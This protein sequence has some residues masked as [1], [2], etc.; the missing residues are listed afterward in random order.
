MIGTEATATPTVTGSTSSGST[1]DSNHPYYLHSSDAPGM[2]LVSSPFDGRG[3]T[4]WRRSVL[5]AISAKNKLG[6]INGTCLEPAL[7]A[8]EHSQW[9]RCN[10][11]V[12]S[13]LL[14]SLTKEIG[15]SVIYSRT[16]KDLWGSL[17]HRFGQSSGAKLYHLQISKLAQGSSSIAGYFT[18]LKRLW[19][20]LDSINSH[21][22][23]TCDCTCDGKKKIAKFMEDQ[24]VIQ[25]LMGLN[26]VYAQARGNILMMSPLPGIDQ[27]YSL[28]LQDESQREIY[29]NPSYSTDVASFMV[30]TQNKTPQRNNQIQR[31]WNP[32]Q[33]QGNTQQKFK[34]KKTR[35][36]P[37][38]A[39]SHCM[40]IGHT[41]ADC[42]RLNGFPDDF[43]FTKSNISQGAVK[44]NALVQIGNGGNPGTEINA[45]AVAGTILKY[46]GT[47]LAVPLMRRGQAFG[48]VRD[49]LYLLQPSS[50][51][52]RILFKQNVISTPKGSN[53]SLFSP[54][55]PF[56]APVFANA[57]SNVRE[58]YVR[59]GHLPFT[60][61]KNLSF[62]HFP[63]TFDYVCDVCPQARQTRLPFP[64]S[65]IRSSSIFDLIHIDT[66][67]PFKTST[68]NGY[69]YFL[70]IVDDF[71]RATWTFL[72]STKSNAF[73]VLKCFLT[74]VEKQF[75]KKVKKIRSDNALELGKGTQESIYLHSQGIQHETSCVATPQQNG[76]IWRENIGIFWKLQGDCYFNQEFQFNIGENVY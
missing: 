52:S 10:N 43:Q 60:A 62:I 7:N 57:I 17:E 65:Q 54:S 49:G 51:E 40:R 19:D 35:Y 36:N 42:Y 56:S 47:C 5:I 73:S 69:K 55:V 76:V 6:F 48:E 2:S 37:N 12:T 14:N 50:L 63:S 61:M 58:W 9:S 41:R 26:D 45:N 29:M 21:L 59:L 33:K 28:L 15:D 39:C 30:G 13:W 64:I 18:T 22:G 25:F 24:R 70:T 3:F 75:N 1:T 32:Q 46:F 67:G 72:L 74:M 44:V 20:E 53:S 11:M 23:C 34:G 31:T 66:W 16:A 4:G 68:Y 27:S 71:S 8:A 38:V